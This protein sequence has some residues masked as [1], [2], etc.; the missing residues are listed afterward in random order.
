M[1]PEAHTP[2]LINLDRQE[3]DKKYELI[4]PYDLSFL[5]G[6][7]LSKQTEYCYCSVKDHINSIYD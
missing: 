1:Y 5:S 3:Q 6:G 2:F 7:F 4:M